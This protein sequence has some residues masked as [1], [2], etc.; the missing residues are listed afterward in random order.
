MMDTYS[1]GKERTVLGVVT[2]K[3]LVLGGSQGR[4]QATGRGCLYVIDKALQ[5]LRMQS[6]G[7]RVVVQGFGNVGMN[8]ALIAAADY[9]MSIIGISDIGGAIFNPH[10]I[11]V[12]ALAQ[13]VAE[14]G[15]IRSF[16]N[17]EP[18]DPDD[19]LKLECEILIPAA[20]SGQITASNAADIR[21][22]IVAEGANGPTTP[23]ADKILHERGILVLPDILANAGGV[24]VSYFEWVQDLQSFFWSEDHIN[25]Q[26][27]KI[28][29]SAFE[30]TWGRA[31]RENCDLRTAALMIGVGT[32]AQAG[33]L[34][35]LYP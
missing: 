2:G 14:N 33:E 9:D 8:A 26:L 22:K 25:E 31:Q 10:G 15:E 21:A 24:T 19:L 35:G 28:M 27:R 11:D 16:P 18:I 23:A 30:R 29:Q 6:R 34:R 3:P 7:A 32:I 1:M 13:Y 4:K 12:K 5:K 20:I 17:T